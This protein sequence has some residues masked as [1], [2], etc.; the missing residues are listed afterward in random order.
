M[1]GE[2]RPPV[3]ASLGPIP[4]SAGFLKEYRI[5]SPLHGLAGTG[6]TMHVDAAVR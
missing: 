4:E 6:I 1:P 3:I 5:R 2:L